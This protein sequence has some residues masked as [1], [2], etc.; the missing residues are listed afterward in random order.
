MELENLCERGAWILQIE[1]GSFFGVRLNRHSGRQSFELKGF[2]VV[3]VI[4]W[5][6]ECIIKKETP[7]PS[8]LNHP[9]NFLLDIIDTSCLSFHIKAALVRPVTSKVVFSNRTLQM[10]MPLA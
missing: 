9:L 6:V 2:L 10:S 8:I 7:D 5:R 3:K 4:R 1:I